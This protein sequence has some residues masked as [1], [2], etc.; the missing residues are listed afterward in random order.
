M[1]AKTILDVKMIN[2]WFD[3]V[4]ALRDISMD[5]LPRTITAIIGPSVC[6]KSTF[7]RCINRLHEEI[8]GA[9]AS[10]EVLLEGKNIYASEIAP[11][12]IRRKIG[13]VFQKPNT[14]HTLSVFDNVVAGLK[15][16]GVRNQTLLAEV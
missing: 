8:P 10:G 7:I 5:F 14:F 6:G 9:S 4:H 11:V 3:K 1:T 16:G 12:R 2:A 15:L 13:M